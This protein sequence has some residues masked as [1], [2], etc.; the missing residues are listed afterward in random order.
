MTRAAQTFS[1]VRRKKYYR[2]GTVVQVKSNQKSDLKHC[3]QTKGSFYRRIS[4]LAYI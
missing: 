4:R 1:T 2:F 3:E